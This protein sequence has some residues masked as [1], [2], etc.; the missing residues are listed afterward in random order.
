MDPP[1]PAKT[2][3]QNWHM[4]HRGL[5]TMT[6]LAQSVYWTNKGQEL[7]GETNVPHAKPHGKK[8]GPGEATQK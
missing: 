5:N 7:Y 8:Y 3:I 2:S 4:G 1:A 6:K